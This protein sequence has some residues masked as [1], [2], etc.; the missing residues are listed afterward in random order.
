MIPIYSETKNIMYVSPL[1]G[2][3]LYNVVKLEIK[4]TINNRREHDDCVFKIK[5]PGDKVF[6]I[7]TS[8]ACFLII[9]YDPHSADEIACQHIMYV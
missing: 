9:Y 7:K 3:K 2:R 6:G 8:S 4:K 5:C 1:P